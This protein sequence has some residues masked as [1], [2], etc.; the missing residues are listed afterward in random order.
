LDDEAP[1]AAE[2]TPD[3]AELPDADADLEEVMTDPLAEGD[4][5]PDPDTDPDAAETG[6][7][8]PLSPREERG[9]PFPIEVKV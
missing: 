4:I 8:V 3:A 1:A 7:T 9:I 2:D 5:D 6:L